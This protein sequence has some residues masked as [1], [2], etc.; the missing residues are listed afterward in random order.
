VING[1]PVFVVSGAI[2]YH[3]CPHELWRD[4][5]LRAKRAG[6]NCVET[7]VA[8]NFHEAQDGIFDFDGDRDIGKFVDTCKDLGLHCFL[9]LGPYIC[10]EWD[11]GG[12]PPWLLAKPGVELRA[13]NDVALHYIRRWFEKLLPQIAA[14]QAPRGGPVILLQAENE[15]FAKDRPGGLEYLEWLVRTLRELGTEVPITD[16]DDTTISVPGSFKTIGESEEA[17]RAFRERYPQWPTMIYEL[18]PGW[19]E[20]WGQP[21]VMPNGRPGELR[22][23]TMR[24]LSLRAMFNYYTFHGGTNFGFWAG[25]SWLSDHSFGVPSMFDSLG[26]KVPFTT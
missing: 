2:H 26:V 13:M 18:Y 1:K 19:G 7:Y 23:R 20:M 22:Q 16:C 17:V 3:R 5:I 6:L 8:W 15:W 14:R 12:Y 24:F 11:G 9:R 21:S 10:G 4:R 25:S